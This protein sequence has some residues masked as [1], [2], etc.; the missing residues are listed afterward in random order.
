MPVNPFGIRKRGRGDVWRHYANLLRDDKVRG[1]LR[2]ADGGPMDKTAKS[3]AEDT[4]SEGTKE[5]MTLLSGIGRK[6]GP[7]LFADRLYD[8]A[9]SVLARASYKLEDVKPI[10]KT[11]AADPRL[12]GAFVSAAINKVISGSDVVELEVQGRKIPYL[13]MCMSK[14]TVI[15]NGDGGWRTGFAMS[16][17]NLIVRGDVGDM[18]A[19]SMSGG[20]F[21]AM[22]NAGNYAGSFMTDGIIGIMGK[23]GC[24]GACITGGRVFV[25][26]I[27][28]GTFSIFS[29][30]S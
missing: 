20:A 1:A 3:A 2:G 21:V 18:A 11:S 19:A 13:G 12:L 15:I 30:K 6:D 27:S 22:R 5:L 7:F 28:T 8:A 9:A 23:M 26:S 14:G 25:G 4:D 24:E 17:G 10:V 16:G 29:Q